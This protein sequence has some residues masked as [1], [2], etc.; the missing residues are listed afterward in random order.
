MSTIGT[1]G[2]VDTME[3][4]MHG[5]IKRMNKWVEWT[6]EK[7]KRRGVVGSSTCVSGGAQTTSAP[8]STTMATASRF[9]GPSQSVGGGG[10]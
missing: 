9:V 7:I 8:T 5:I 2:R 3:V 1:L 10:D 4:L 6:R